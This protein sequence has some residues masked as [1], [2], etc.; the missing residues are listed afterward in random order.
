MEAIFVV[1]PDHQRCDVL[2]ISHQPGDVG[3]SAE[4]WVR[5]LFSAPV[6]AFCAPCPRRHIS[7]SCF[8]EISEKTLHD[9]ETVVALLV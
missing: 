7:H 2:L 1:V 8:F 9:T 4:S 3:T 5:I 6:E